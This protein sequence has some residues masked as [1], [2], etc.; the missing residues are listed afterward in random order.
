MVGYIV[1]AVSLLYHI[2]AYTLE[3]DRSH[4]F[5]RAFLVLSVLGLAATT[6]FFLKVPWQ[7]IS[8][9]AR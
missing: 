1:F 8:F 6:Y 9:M 7:A 4:L 3:R 2:R 5:A